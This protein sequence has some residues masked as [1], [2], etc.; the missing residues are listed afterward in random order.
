M[1]ATTVLGRFATTNDDALYFLKEQIS[2]DENWR[3]Q[4]FE[5]SWKSHFTRLDWQN[6]IF[7]IV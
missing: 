6:Y 5:Y 3:V 4:A 1:L 2:T 7:V